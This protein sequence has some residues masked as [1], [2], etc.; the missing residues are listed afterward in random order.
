MIFALSLRLQFFRPHGGCTLAH[1]IPQ[2]RAWGYRI[3][4]ALRALLLAL[5]GEILTTDT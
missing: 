2:A 3:A 5:T 1:R 4:P